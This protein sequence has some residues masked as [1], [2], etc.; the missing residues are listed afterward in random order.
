MLDYLVLYNSQS[1][2][3]KSVA[4]AIFS[5][6]PEGSRDLIDIDS[7]KPIPE[8]S[9]YFIG[10]C[11]HRGS[12]CIEVSDLLSSLENKNIA[13]FGTCGMGRSAEYYSLIEKNVSAWINSSC[14]YLGCYICQ[15][16]MPMQVRQKYENMRTSE[17][18]PQV[19]GF[20]RNFDCAM[21]HPDRED[22]KKAQE[23]ALSCMP[24]VF[25]Q[26]C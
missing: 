24:P 3:T 17:N 14:R 7:G 23:F 6:L 11:I 20:I 9:T 2:N 12:C 5:A 26:I 1:G 8:A 22:L 15:G 25:K 21:T 16:K 10:F 18:A 4:A 13:L 19:D